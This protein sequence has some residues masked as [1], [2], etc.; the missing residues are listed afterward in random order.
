M[1]YSSGVILGLAIGLPLGALIALMAAPTQ[2]GGEQAMTTLQIQDISD[3]VSAG[4]DRQ[5]RPMRERIEELGRRMAEF[6]EVRADGKDQE[7]R[8]EDVLRAMQA[9]LDGIEQRA[10]ARPQ[11]AQPAAPPAPEWGRYEAREQP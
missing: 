5:I 11:A 4:I 7:G 3:K 2:R 1:R 6:D 8:I 9:R 10:A